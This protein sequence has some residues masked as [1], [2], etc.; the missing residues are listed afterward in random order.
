MDLYKSVGPKSGACN[1]C[2][3]IGPLTDDHVP[4]RGC[5]TPRP[6][7]LRSIVARSPRRN[8]NFA[9]GATKAPNGTIFRTLCSRCNNELL[10]KHCDPDLISM[11]QQVAALFESPL[12]LPA[13]S[14]IRIRP[15][16][17][18]RSVLG[19]LSAIGI[20]RSAGG[21]LTDALR[22]YLL[23]TN[24]P[25]P[26]DLRLYYWGYQGQERVLVRDAGVMT[27]NQRG[28]SFFWLMKFRPLAFMAVWKG[29][30]S[31]ANLR[32]FDAYKSSTFDDVA[33][34]P[35]DAHPL[36]NEYWPELPQSHE[37][38]MY[39]RDAIVAVDREPRGRPLSF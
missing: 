22:S 17:V 27:L 18:A 12:Y 38:I 10:G 35:F 29:Q 3:N 11:T 19:H 9:K 24:A 31:A 13:T 21:E 15:Q 16:R 20:D 5:A 37:M 36:P 30:L 14:I 23:D 25:M 39:G 34:L 7:Y 32:T 8:K 26:A 33:D 28:H 1:I 6:T 2:G 4:P